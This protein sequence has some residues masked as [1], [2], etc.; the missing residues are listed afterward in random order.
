MVNTNDCWVYAGLLNAYGYGY[1]YEFIDGKQC[2]QMVHRVMYEAVKNK[3]PKGL[4]IDHLCRNRSCINPDHLEPITNRQNVL[5][6]EGYAAK[7][8]KKTH[9]IRGH[10]LKGVNLY[11]T[12]SGKRNCKKCRALSMEKYKLAHR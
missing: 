3:I 4:Y 9:C 8:A 1:V 7:N 2:N 6:G 11:V 10:I 12:P 5:R